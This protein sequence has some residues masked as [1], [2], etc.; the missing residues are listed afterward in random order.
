VK[1]PTRFKLL[2]QTIEVKFC[3]DSRFVEKDS[4]IGF[5]S[6]RLNSIFI[7]PNSE[8]HPLTTEQIEEAFFHELMHFVTYY[9]GA[10]Y[11]G[12][13]EYMHQDEGFI[14]MCAGLLHQAFSTMEYD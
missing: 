8:A 3:F 1:I 14:D 10:A 5:A 11:S 4:S 6:Y 13:H 12:K 9:A 7:K 2:G